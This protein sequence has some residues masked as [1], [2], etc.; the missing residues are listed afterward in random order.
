MLK[1]K[2]LKVSKDEKIILEK[3]NLELETGKTHVIMGPNGSGKS[4]IAKTLAGHPDYQVGFDQIS[5]KYQNS[6]LNLMDFSANERSLKGVFLSFQYPIEI[7]GISNLVFLK[8]IYETHC[9]YQ[10]AATNIS[11]DDFIELL[12][13]HLKILSMDEKFLHRAVNV[14]FSGGEKKKN[15]ILQLLLLN[16]KLAILDEV[17]SGLDIDS[18]KIVASGVNKFKN[19]KNT[20]LLIT[21]YQRLLDYIKPDYIHVMDQGKIIK[22]GDASLAIELEKKGYDWL[23][24]AN[25]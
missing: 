8:S 13:P 18:L 11:D 1:I 23:K 24:V 9:E 25:K 3:F 15:E 22:T 16:P 14:G 17:D 6:D 2:N 4:T 5:Y 19:S 21:H 20:L 7:P 10:G 12:R